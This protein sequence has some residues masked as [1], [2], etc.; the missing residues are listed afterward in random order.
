MDGG[1]GVQRE[2]LFRVLGLQRVWSWG[3]EV[4]QA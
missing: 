3:A 2:Q 4:Q 1:F